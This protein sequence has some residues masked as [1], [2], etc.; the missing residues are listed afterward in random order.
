MHVLSSSGRAGR[1]CNPW[2]GLFASLAGYRTAAESCH[3]GQFL[4]ELTDSGGQLRAPGTHK[5]H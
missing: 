2:H 3:F 1:N 4:A 5:Y